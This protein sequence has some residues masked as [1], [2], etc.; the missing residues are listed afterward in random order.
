MSRRLAGFANPDAVIAYAD[1]VRTVHGG[2]AADGD[3]AGLRVLNG[4]QHGLTHDL[5]QMHLLLRVQRQRGEAAVE[6]QLR[7][8]L[9]LQDVEG[10][11]QRRG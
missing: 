6:M 11:L 3:L 10:L 8:R 2:H 4:V 1:A 9:A 5:Q 7:L